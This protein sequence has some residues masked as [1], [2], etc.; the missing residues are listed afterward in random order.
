M[1]PN[2]PCCHKHPSR[3]AT[4]II[5]NTAGSAYRCEACSKRALND[6]YELTD[7]NEHTHYKMN[8]DGEVTA[9]ESALS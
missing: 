5:A 4:H 3:Y 1:N 6:G 7:L 8:S 9:W 2:N